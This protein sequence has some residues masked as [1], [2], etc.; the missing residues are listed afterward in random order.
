LFHLAAIGAEH[1][2]SWVPS[3]PLELSSNPLTRALWLLLAAGAVACLTSARRRVRQAGLA[4]GVLAAVIG[5]NEACSLAKGEAWSG[6]RVISFA[7]CAGLVLVS[8]LIAREI[9]PDHPQ[10]A[11][12]VGGFVVAYPVVLRMGV[13]FHPE[14]PLAFLCSLAILLFLRAARLGWP[15][16]LGWA[17]G[18]TCGAAALTRQTAI[19]AIVCIAVAAAFLGGRR[20]GG[21]LVRAAV[22]L[23]I[24]AGP[25]WVYAYR[26]WHNP[27]QSNLEPRASLMMSHQPLSFYVSFPLRTLVVHPYRPDFDDQLLPKLHAELWS[28]WFGA[29]HGGWGSA[30]RLDRVTASTQSVLGFAGDALAIVGL[31]GIAAP[32]GVRVVSRRSRRASDLGLGF[33]AL[34]TVTALAGF[35]LMLIRFPQQFG[36]PIKSSYLL[37]TAPAWAVFSVAAWAELR[38]RRAKAQIALAG[39]AALYAISYATHLGSVFA[40]PSAGVTRAG[41]DLHS[42]IQGSSPA[43]VPGIDL[44]FAIFVDNAGSQPANHVTLRIHVPPGMNLLGLPY[45]ERGSGCT[46]TR[47]LTCNLDLLSPGAGTLVRFE[48]QASQIGVQMLTASVFSDEP[49]AKQSDNDVVFTI[50]VAA[51]TSTT[52]TSG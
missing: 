34:F 26:T 50:D 17:V 32:A 40:Q 1:A 25:W 27:F 3:R 20:A 28:D 22:L 21:F 16:R 36:D 42:S 33:L 39:V 51:P 6:G 37:F 47:T 18:A 12:A 11:L 46:G 48:L 8:G 35:L 38:R 10:R 30:T 14:M 9:W 23:A 49:D 31:A 29:F 44:M 7:T 43:A 2:A 45:Y 15:R 4:A 19:V 52:T 5:L 41:V 24:V 13:L